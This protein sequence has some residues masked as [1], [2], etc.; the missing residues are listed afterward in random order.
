M[1]LV[2]ALVPSAGVVLLFVLAVRGM[3]QADRRERAA[4]ARMDATGRTG[5]E[6]EGAGPEGGAAA[7]D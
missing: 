2:L 7:E 3:L 6:G 4:Q 1:E 5:A